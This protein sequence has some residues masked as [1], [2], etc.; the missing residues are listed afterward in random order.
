MKKRE[1]FLTTV[2]YSALALDMNNETAHA[3]LIAQ[4]ASAI[5]EDKIPHCPAN[6]AKVFVAYCTG[7]S[8]RPYAW[9]F[10]AANF[11]ENISHEKV[12]QLR[13]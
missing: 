4:I 13:P 5:P 6:A 1:Q 12:V 8:R 9:M 10:F 11:K 3:Q 7:V 2:F